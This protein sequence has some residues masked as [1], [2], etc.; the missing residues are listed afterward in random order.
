MGIG[1]LE[2]F[3][4][5]EIWRVDAGRGDGLLRVAVDWTPRPHGREGTGPRSR[6]LPLQKVLPAVAPSHGYCRSALLA[7]LER[8]N[9]SAIQPISDFRTPAAGKQWHTV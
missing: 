8:L 7:T 5:G 9:L 2:R 4:G 3:L 1:Q 6:R